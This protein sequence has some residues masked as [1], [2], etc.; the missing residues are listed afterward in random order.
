MAF[1]KAPRRIWAPGL[2]FA[3]FGAATVLGPNLLH[4]VGVVEGGRLNSSASR[5]A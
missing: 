1:S 5:K 3:I 2:L 4:R